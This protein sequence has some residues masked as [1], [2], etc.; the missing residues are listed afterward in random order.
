MRLSLLLLSALLLPFLSAASP[1]P[2]SSPALSARAPIIS[3][4]SA[5]APPSRRDDKFAPS[6]LP[7]SLNPRPRW[8]RSRGSMQC[9]VGVL[10]K[11]RRGSSFL[12]SIRH[13]HNRAPG[14]SSCVP[15]WLLLG[16][17]RDRSLGDRGL[18]FPCSWLQETAI[19]RH[20]NCCSDHGLGSSHLCVSS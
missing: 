7:L 18:C 16:H 1:T 10:P 14:S 19:L 11:L 2:V 12:H 3:P 20:C 4:P 17:Y 13:P 6:I 5:T 9:G 15:Q 8:L